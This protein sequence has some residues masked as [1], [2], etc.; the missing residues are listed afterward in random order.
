VVVDARSDEEY[1]GTPSTVESPAE[2]GH[3]EGAY[4]LPYQSILS[5]DKPNY[6]RSDT[7]LKELF[8]N[9]GMDPGKTAVV[10]C[11]SGVRA[12]VNYLVA[13]HL[14]YTVLLYDG[15]YEEWVN[16][17]LPLT[18]PVDPPRDND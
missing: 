6:F 13:R 1:Y 11:G 18:G 14:H 15:S 17:N 5:D 10:Y 2:G 7:E 4:F 9:A 3:I 16:M 12:S 8:R